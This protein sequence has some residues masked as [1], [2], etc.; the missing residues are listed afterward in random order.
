MTTVDV[1]PNHHSDYPSFRGLTGFAAG[2]SMLFG[3]AATARLAIELAAVVNTD[4]VVDIGCGPG[5]AARAAARRGAD[6]IGVDPAPPMLALARRATGRGG[7]VTWKLGA[8]ESLPVADGWATVVW[9]IA[10][11]HHWRD[12]DRGLAETCR[13]L[14]P[15]SRLVVI[16]RRVRP[17]ATGHASHGWTEAQAERFAEL[18][19]KAGLCGA[20]ATNHRSGRTAVLA[21]T[22]T[23]RDP[24]R[25]T[26]G[27]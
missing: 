26:R 1:V 25:E 7:T 20:R 11:V 8:A 22:A 21:V 13:V 19:T 3:R 2:I 9:S 14:A 6:V 10:A 27:L 4:R 18:C 17:G 5:T 24:A 23:T 15:C 16:E 12:L